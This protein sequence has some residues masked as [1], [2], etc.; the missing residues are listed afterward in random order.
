MKSIRSRDN[1]FVKQLVALAH[2]S[3]ERR[4]AGLTVLD[5]IHL[6]RAH[7]D[8][9][10][11]PHA[12]AVAESMLAHDEVAGVLAGCRPE[13]INVLADKLM[14]AASSLDSP[15]F[16][17]AMVGTPEPRAISPA[18]TVLVLEDVQDPGNV[19]SMLRSAAAA[20]IT[21]V[22]LSK[23]TAFA[24]SPKVLRA[25]QGAH[26][27]LNI[28]EG[29]DVADFVRHYRGLSLALVPGGAGVARLYD[30]DMR[31]PTAILI[32]NE[33]NGLSP[34]LIA[35]ATQR[36]TIPMPGRIESL[37]AAAAGAICLFELSRQRAQGR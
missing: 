21:E 33:G 8:A 23:S 29:A 32:G 6:V 35:G 28:V 31:G 18:A 10:G 3:R 25:A 9:L 30:V 22:L 14:A 13:T 2:S 34:A 24:W 37:N 20:G 15:A 4:K 5:G 7:I 36:A 17:M 11:P 19:G 16:M 27:L 1:A 26:F 12:V